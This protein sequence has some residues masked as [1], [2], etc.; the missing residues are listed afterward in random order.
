M[1]DALAASAV[2]AVTPLLIEA[3]K[4]GAEKLGETAIGRLLRWLRT[5]TTGRAQEALADLQRAPDSPDNQADP[6][7]Q[8]AKFLE[9]NPALLEE[10]R[11]L[12]PAPGA[13][14]DT[15]KQHVEGAGAKGVQIK[16]GRNTVTM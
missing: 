8:L 2:A 14:G 13:A 15:M 6:R 5:K 7:K 4:G 10:M 9:Q 1:I 11:A 3:G 12:L 16:G